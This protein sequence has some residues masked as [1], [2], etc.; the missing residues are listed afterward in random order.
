MYKNIWILSIKRLTQIRSKSRK[1]L[2]S[3]I[4]SKVTHQKEWY[5]STEKKLFKS[6]K[7]KESVLTI[8]FPFVF[9]FQTASNFTSVTVGATTSGD[10]HTFGSFGFTFQ[11]K[12]SII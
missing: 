2:S 12:K 5:E 4:I 3:Y 8:L 11:F 1:I 6:I 7:T 9:S 10:R